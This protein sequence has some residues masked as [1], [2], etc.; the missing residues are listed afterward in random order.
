[1][2]TISPVSLLIKVTCRRQHKK[3]AHCEETIDLVLDI[4]LKSNIVSKSESGPERHFKTVVH[5][6][7]IL[8]EKS[9]A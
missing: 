6:L 4:N 1:M 3:I 8:S 7:E 2:K 5:Q 9:Y